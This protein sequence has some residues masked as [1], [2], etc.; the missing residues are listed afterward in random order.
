MKTR[1]SILGFTLIELVMV[2]VLIGIL[3]I[4]VLPRFFDRNTFDARGY[5]DQSI[6]MVRYAQKLAIAQRR[7]VF[8]NVTG[9]SMCLTYATETTCAG[10]P[11]ANQVIN[12]ADQAWFVKTA[13]AGMIFTAASSFSFNALGQPSSSKVIRFTGDGVSTDITIESETGYVH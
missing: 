7:D 10:A 4:A 6:S 5:F 8:V 9:N 3:A 2:M 11:V 12:P 1:K 13:P